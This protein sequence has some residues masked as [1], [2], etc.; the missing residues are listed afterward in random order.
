MAFL[1]S[2]DPEQAL[3][4]GFLSDHDKKTLAEVRAADANTLASTTFG[5]YDQRL[6]ELLFRYRARNFPGSLSGQEQAQWREHCQ[7]RFQ[8]DDDDRILNIKTLNQR[9]DALLEEHKDHEEKLK[10]LR[11]LKEYGEMLVKGAS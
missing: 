7:Q 5:F 8:A 9:V 4:Q 2:A 3:Y 1:S 10:I 11:A 6:P